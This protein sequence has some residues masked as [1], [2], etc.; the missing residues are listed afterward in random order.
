MDDKDW[1]NL[2]KYIEENREILQKPLED[3]R[4][5]FFGDSITE[6]WKEIMPEY[7]SEHKYVNRGIGGQTTP[8]MLIRF[9]Q[10]VVKLNP[11]L[12]I[13][14]AGTNDIAGN[15][16]PSSLEMIM[17]NIMSMVEISTA[18]GIKVILSSVL[19]AYDYFWAPGLQP[20]DKI[21][22]LNRLI[23][24]YADKKAIEYLDYYSKLVDE[25]KGLVESFTIDGVHLNE[26]GYKIMIPIAQEGISKALKS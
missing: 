20:A 1:A 11:S 3:N 7:F 22:E 8:Q 14:L 17:D 23:K 10:D 19:P 26:K 6:Q 2:S 12:V 5:I 25:K 15:T 21:F 24:S 9:R 13:I 18:N 16:G 4:I